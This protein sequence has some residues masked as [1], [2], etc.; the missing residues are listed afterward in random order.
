MFKLQKTKLP[1]LWCAEKNILILGQE[2]S[3]EFDKKQILKL[4]KNKCTILS[5]NINRYIPNKLV[6]FHI[7]SDVK[8]IL[9][10]N[11]IIKI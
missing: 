7:V 1:K 2:K 3:V 11:I 6:D 8:G 9:W 10:I 5:L 4:Q